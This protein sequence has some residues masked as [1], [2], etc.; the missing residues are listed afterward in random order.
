[1]KTAEQIHLEVENTV[2]QRVE[3]FLSER[4]S[5]YLGHIKG[6]LQRDETIANE[7]QEYLA[8]RISCVLGDMN[9]I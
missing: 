2:R 4:S 1:M 8:M 3:T 7:P 9:L 6:D 5:A